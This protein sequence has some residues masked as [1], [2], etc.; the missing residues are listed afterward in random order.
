MKFTRRA[1][2]A[3]AASAW[4]LTA[5]AGAWAADALKIGAYPANPP[6]EYKN[7]AGEFEG[8][9]VDIVNEVA[10]RM[11]TTAEISG[12]DFKALFV[13]TASGRVDAVISSLT[14]TA[15]RLEA[16]AFSQPYVVG[17]LGVAVKDGS[18]ITTQA[19][20]KGKTVGAIATSVGETWLKENAEQVGYGD[21]KSYNS[22]ANMLTDLRTGR[23]DAV[24][25]DAIGT[26]YAL[27]QAQGL[28]VVDEIITGEKYAMMFPKNSEKLEE[29]N[30]ILSDMKTDGTMAAIYEKWLGV[31]PA[32]DS[33]TVT[34]MPVP[35]A[36]E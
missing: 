19:D 24:V 31:A 20:L 12:L 16:Q 7:E 4:A 27:S 1:A 36:A 18:D 2:L 13:A 3:I 14:I 29:I 25:N 11:G 33:V 21:Y 28:S 8:F 17:A 30:A 22:T 32:A 23:V 34:P 6:W 10:K 9:E 35:T 26:R 15:E 5:G